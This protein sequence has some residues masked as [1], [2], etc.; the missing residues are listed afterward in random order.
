MT[1]LYEKLQHSNLGRELNANKRLQWL[2]ALVAILVMLSFGKRAVDSVAPA[3]NELAMELNLLARLQHSAAQPFDD[4]QLTSAQI[5]AQQARQRIDVAPSASTAEA[6]ALALTEFTFKPLIERSRITL[7][8]SQELNFAGQRFF[9][10]RMEMNGQ[11]DELRLIA[12]LKLIDRDMP[13]TRLSSLQYAPK[14]S[15]TINAVVDMLFVR[16]GDE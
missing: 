5:L 12:L 3:Q 9:Q 14:A 11:L 13:G 16:S 8:G 10:V 1:S 7:L 4:E 2:I 6:Q 15:N